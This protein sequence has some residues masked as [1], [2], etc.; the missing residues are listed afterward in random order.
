MDAGVYYIG[1]KNPA[2]FKRNTYVYHID[3]NITKK[4]L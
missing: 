3:N 1:D 4:T 2:A